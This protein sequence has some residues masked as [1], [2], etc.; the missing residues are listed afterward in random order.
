MARYENEAL[1]VSFEL[2][3]RMSVRKQLEFRS[4]IANARGES[5]YTRF[6]EAAAVI[7]DKWQ[8]ELI[9]DPAALDLDTADDPRVADIVQWAANTVAGHITGLEIPSKK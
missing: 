9:P 8:C 6:W 1:G 4:R 7:V 3:E 2:P 5:S